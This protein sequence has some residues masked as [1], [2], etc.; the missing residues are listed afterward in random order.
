MTACKSAQAAIAMLTFAQPWL[1][2]KARVH[3]GVPHTGALPAKCN[4]VVGGGRKISS[5][6]HDFGTNT[7]GGK[8]FQQQC[9]ILATI[10]NMRFAHATVQ[11][12]QT[13]LDFG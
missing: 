12:R 5:V 2:K 3:G 8:H 10:D 1:F 13:S 7:P 4:L 6:G 9:M 11:G